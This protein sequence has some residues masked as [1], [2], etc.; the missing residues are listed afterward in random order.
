MTTTSSFPVAP[1]DETPP[2]PPKGRKKPM[3][4][5]VFPKI[6]AAS[7]ASVNGTATH[8]FGY[9]RNSSTHASTKQYVRDTSEDASTEGGEDD[10]Y[11]DW[12]EQ[13][14][15]DPVGACITRMLNEGKVAHFGFRSMVP[16]EQKTDVVEIFSWSPLLSL[17]NCRVVHR[18][19]RDFVQSLS[20]RYCKLDSAANNTQ[21]VEKG[22]L[23]K[24]PD[25]NRASMWFMLQTFVALYIT[26]YSLNDLFLRWSLESVAF[27]VFGL[28]STIFDVGEVKHAS[29]FLFQLCPQ[30]F[31]TGTLQCMRIVRH[32][33]QAV[34]SRILWG[35]R[36]QGRFLLWSEEE[37]LLKFRHKH[38]RVMKINNERR[39]NR[40]QRK[41]TRSE[42]RK[43]E[44]RGLSL[45]SC[46]FAKMEAELA[47]KEALD[48]AADELRRKPPTYFQNRLYSQKDAA[49]KF[50]QGD[51]TKKHFDSLEYCHHMIFRSQMLVETK[52][53]SISTNRMGSSGTNALSPREAIEV[54]EEFP[55][56]KVNAI[57]DHDNL[58]HAETVSSVASEYSLPD[59]YDFN[60][61]D[62]DNSSDDD[63][64]NICEGSE[65][66][67]ELSE[68][69]YASE[70]EVKKMDWIA[71]G[72]KIGTKILKSRQVH[73]VISNPN[74][75]GTFL[76]EEAKKLID[77]MKHDHPEER[78]G[79]PSKSSTWE[80]QQSSKTKELDLASSDESKSTDVF[81][82]KP[83]VH[84]MW[85]SAGS[86]AA[87]S[88]SYGAVTLPAS[89][90]P[91]PRKGPKVFVSSARESVE[92]LRESSDGCIVDTTN[93][94][95][96]GPILPAE[97]MK[98][99]YN[100][101]MSMSMPANG[102]FTPKN[103]TPKH[104]NQA[105]DFTPPRTLFPISRSDS[106]TRLAPMEKG[107]K[108]VVPVF[109]PN[110][111]N[112][113]NKPCFYQMGTVISS[114]RICVLSD[115]VS[116]KHQK[117]SLIGGNKEETNCLAIKLVLDRAILRG[118][119][120]AEMNIRI[121]DEW[122]WIPR[123]S[124]YPI[125]SCVATTFG[126]GVLVGWR[127]EDDMHIIRSLWNRSGPGTGLAYL[128]RECLHSVVEAAVGFDVETKLGSGR[129]AAY[130]RG[131]P[132]NTDG[133]YFVHLKSR[134]R[135]Q[136]RVVEF[137]R[138]QIISCRVAKFIPVTEHI[139]AAALYQL[140]TLHYK[141]KVREHMLNEPSSQVRQKGT[142]RKF[143][144]Y[145]DLFAAS[146]SK[147]IAEDPDFD[148]E[149]DK[150]MTHIINVLDDN[151]DAEEISLTSESVSDG[152]NSSIQSDQ[153]RVIA[154]HEQ[155][156]HW[157]MQDT[158]ASFFAVNPKKPVKTEP[159][160]ELVQSQ[161]QKFQEAHHSL[162]VILRVLL[163]TVAVA[164]AS[165]PNRPKLHIALAMI[166][167][168]L[169]FVRQVV[170][171]QNKNISKAL[172]EAWLRTM[173]EISRTF[174]PLKERTAAL[175][176]K[177]AKKLK[178]HSDI[179]KKRVLS[180]VDIVLGDTALL[181][182]LE[183]GD[184][185]LS[186]LRLE[187]ALV[188]S[189]ITDEATCEQLHRGVLCWKRDRQSK[190]AARRTRIKALRFAK[191]MKIIASPG[192]S[193][194]RLLASD[195]VLELFDRVL[196][197]VF[198]ND[199]ECSMMI[200]IHA[201][202]FRSLRYLRTLNNMAVA[203]KLWET[204]LDA[205]DEELTFVTSE[206][207][208]QTKYFVDPFIKLFSIGVAKFHSIQSGDSNADWLD[209]LMEEDAVKII[210]DLDMKIIDCLDSFCKDVKQL[211][212]VMPYIKTI[213]NDILNLMDELDFDLMFK[214]ITGSI[215]DSDK[216]AS[217]IT[218]RSALLVERFLDY[219]PRMSI[220]I[221]KRDLQDGW[222]LTCRGSDG[223]DLRLSD[224]NVKRENLLCQVLGSEN[225]FRP[226]GKDDYIG[227]P[228]NMFPHPSFES[229]A[230][231]AHE[232]DGCV[233]EEVREMIL[234]AQNHGCW[235]P[236]L[237]GL[238]KPFFYSGVPTLLGDL[239]LSEPLKTGID[240]WQ[241][242]AISDFEFTQLAVR[243]VSRQIHLQSRIEDNAPPIRRTSKK[244]SPTSSPRKPFIPQIDSTV[245][246]L[247]IKNL[248]LHLNEFIFRVEKGENKTIFDPVFEG[249]GSLT[250]K[251]V[252]ISLRIEAKKELVMKNGCRIERPLLQL[253]SFDIRLEKLVIS[254]KETGAD[255]ILNTVLKGFRD[256]ITRV[257]EDN[258]REQIKNQVLIALEHV[259]GLF[260]TNSELLL[261]ILGTTLD[262]LEE[263]VT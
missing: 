11:D 152:G 46:D 55:D 126:I 151:K 176:K 148:R 101:K 177:M 255:W 234:S 256:Q 35:Q 192:R 196:L 182:S 49:A 218:E 92:L 226:L 130:I 250:V 258:V 164:K 133:K 237:G 37:R 95:I 63:N 187:Y 138:N 93:D 118:C 113:L 33:Y 17:R 129:V 51:A 61:D 169:L 172:I 5:T 231:D 242:S 81:M 106:T 74:K 173:N 90:S 109:A 203:G 145:V 2:Y 65:D 105:F 150:F 140:E 260:D 117:W 143:S 42:Q 159:D 194:L 18:I 73:R 178:K 48:A 210:Q 108:I 222:V 64:D 162:S 219:L 253:A 163:R 195:D 36:F 71:V 160:N 86:A 243:E 123:F 240:L 207:P 205:I 94:D 229:D 24:Q 168:S 189:N 59:K 4:S 78:F 121:M 191:F 13:H 114:S 115:E 214:E 183:R 166:H 66:E 10:E 25:M 246:L 149:V 147:A 82:P 236:G 225:V 43:K 206:L 139:R 167:E 223:G 52:T 58:S 224:I 127:V 67:A 262:D 165:V 1:S 30:S 181:H 29:L 134:G 91:T 144:E 41:R 112:G 103:D 216:F 70:E 235:N 135:Y 116:R 198:D 170:R 171:V 8:S 208:D 22:S 161:V 193:F 238:E 153:L 257:V 80:S 142:W 28:L 220:P 245:L 158:F 87:S 19:V 174:G 180:F 179:A 155:S 248:T 233:L 232:K 156:Q 261:K 111:S 132:T 45:D 157:N 211:F 50:I 120:F 124:K 54:T 26:I 16:L 89:N 200:N 31:Q 44:R 97:F 107:V 40:R 12:G 199:P 85:T 202:N 241:S 154:A 227:S 252:S 184:W 239:P 263:R 197:R 102:S 77:G 3:I 185:K 249:A 259:N 215:G 56:I 100:L 137:K 20:C 75:V 62:D 244:A 72:A 9:A 175:G 217:Y 201:F 57:G 122:N 53:I 110:V 47:V 230:D 7:T 188:K 98:S 60:S 39:L 254:F 146:L 221:E 88:H 209:F 99:P 104:S 6:A 119:K 79:S 136:D 32:M 204:V 23:K 128:R 69:S 212:E 38:I 141:A 96:N 228:K 27:V 68:V 213:D 15:H 251:N 131:G 247:D 190:A 84:G 14:Q 186:L 83:P 34:E 76:P 125:G 21:G